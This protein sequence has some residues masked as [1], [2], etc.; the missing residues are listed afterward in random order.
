VIDNPY[1]NFDPNAILIVTMNGTYGAGSG[2]GYTIVPE[3]TGTTP[4]GPQINSVIS[5]L[6]FYNGPGSGFYA[7]SPEYAKEKWCIRTYSG[8]Y[9]ADARNF[10]FNV[11][12]VHP[13]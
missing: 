13:N 12:I 2:L 1:C 10:N 11:M 5:F 8:G 6:V 3:V 4:T 9:V 7:G